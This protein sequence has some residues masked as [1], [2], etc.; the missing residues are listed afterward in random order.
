MMP[1]PPAGIPYVP[2]KGDIV[3]LEL[4]PVRGQEMDK[5]RPALVL[6]E[7]AFNRRPGL[8][9]VAAISNASSGESTEVPLLTNLKV[10]G[11]IMVDQ[12]RSV[13]WRARRARRIERVPPRIVDDTL[14]R[15][16]AILGVERAAQADRVA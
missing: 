14:D 1:K 6:S 11:T 2:A 3:L 10:T 13:D 15:L 8:C 4:G 16:Y 7:I 9:Y 5:A 12:V